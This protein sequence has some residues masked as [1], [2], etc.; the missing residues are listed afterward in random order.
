MGGRDPLTFNIFTFFII[1]TSTRM[2]HFS[3][4]RE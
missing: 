1:Y 4:K 2:E 3:S